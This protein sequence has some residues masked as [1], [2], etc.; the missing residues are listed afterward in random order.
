MNSTTEQKKPQKENNKKKHTR[1]FEYFLYDFVK[2]TG[3]LP[4]L[5][6]MRTKT[7]YVGEKKSKKIRGGALLSSNHV[8][9]LDPV[10][11]H[12]ALWRRR[13]HCVATKELYDTPLKN[14]FFQSMHCIKVDRENFS[15]STFHGVKEGLDKEKLVLIFPEGQVNH[16]E[17]TVLAF[18]SGA[19][20]MAHRCNKPIVPIY[21][22][23]RNKWYERQKVMIGTPVD[24]RSLCGSIPTMDQLNS[25]SEYLHQ[26]EIELQEKYEQIYGKKK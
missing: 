13:I 3:A 9:F 23:K 17:G 11:V 14:F 4:M 25:A 21:I 26:K 19:I 7:V 22:A 1:P 15:M 6:F 2:I 5:L 20:L 10:I 12:T 24:I 18:K 16:Q 8:S